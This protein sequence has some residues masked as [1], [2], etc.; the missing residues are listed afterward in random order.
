MIETRKVHCNIFQVY[1]HMQNPCPFFFCL[2]ILFLLRKVYYLS[3]RVFHVGV[4]WL[5]T[6]GYSVDT[7]W[8]WCGPASI[9]SHCDAALDDCP[10][11]TKSTLSSHKESLRN[12]ALHVSLETYNWLSASDSQAEKYSSPALLPPASMALRLV[13]RAREDA[14]KSV[15]TKC[16]WGC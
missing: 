12:L 5:H 6:C 16:W 15:N 9:C 8:L 4:C 1:F 10:W 2:F 3:Y 7:T 11:A 14:Q 13:L